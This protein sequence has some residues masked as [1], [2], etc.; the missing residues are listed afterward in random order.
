[1]QNQILNNQIKLM[2]EFINKYIVLHKFENQ[3]KNID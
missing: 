3:N 2:N 1:M